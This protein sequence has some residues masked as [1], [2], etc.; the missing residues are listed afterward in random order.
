MNKWRDIQRFKERNE[1]ASEEMDRHSEILQCQ[2][3]QAFSVKSQII[4]ILGYWAIQLSQL[5]NSAIV[6]QKQLQT[7]CKL[8]SVF[9]AN[10]ML[11]R[12]TGDGLVLAPGPSIPWR[13]T[14]T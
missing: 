1:I 4:N 8:M 6:V 5:H 3:W 12:K 9:G 10:K 2:G 14:R 13:K 7:I 11:F